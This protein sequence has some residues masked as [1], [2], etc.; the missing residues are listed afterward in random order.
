M[1]DT[2]F[3]SHSF[4]F[5]LIW[6]RKRKHKLSKVRV[7]RRID[8]IGCL[9]TVPLRYSWKG[10]GPTG[11]VGVWNGLD[12]PISPVIW[13]QFHSSY[14]KGTLKYKDQNPSKFCLE[15]DVN[16]SKVFHKV[17]LSCLMFCKEE[18]LRIDSVYQPISVLS[19]L[20]EWNDVANCVESG[21]PS[22]GFG[23]YFA[24][25]EMNCLCLCPPSRQLSVVTYVRLLWG[26]RV[27][28]GSFPQATP[29][30]ERC[31]LCKAAGLP[32]SRTGTVTSFAL[33]SNHGAELI[34]SE[35]KHAVSQAF[36]KVAEESKLVS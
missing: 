22:C 3:F 11:V 20:C 24:G 21:C 1:I 2:E 10:N 16:I 15:A 19:F 32:W 9:E 4:C 34:I 29:Y 28:L 35:N 23:S 26:S 31:S 27:G 7:G 14:R 17:Y 30:A 25:A 36:G 13:A 33:L 18:R 6:V 5:L 8:A 12:K